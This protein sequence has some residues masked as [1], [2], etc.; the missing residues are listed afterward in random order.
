MFRLDYCAVLCDKGC[1]ASAGFRCKRDDV[2]LCSHRD[3]LCMRVPVVSAVTCLCFGAFCQPFVP[4]V[5][6]ILK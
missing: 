5:V 3:V 6:V 4:R 1:G 2:E